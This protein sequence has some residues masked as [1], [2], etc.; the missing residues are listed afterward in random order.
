MS[1]VKDLFIQIINNILES[2]MSSGYN[3]KKNYHLSVGDRHRASLFLLLHYLHKQHADDWYWLEAMILLLRNMLYCSLS[4]LMVLNV[5]YH[6][7]LSLYRLHHVTF[8][9]RVLHYE[10]LFGVAK[11]KKKNFNFK[12]WLL[13]M[14]R[15]L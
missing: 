4:L 1:L 8:V 15:I 10:H 9:D 11:W 2:T 7:R 14:K 3:F 5:K 13:T 6:D 12:F